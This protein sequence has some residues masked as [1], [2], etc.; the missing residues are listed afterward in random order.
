MSQFIPG[1][2]IA[3]K[4]GV[5]YCV[6]WQAGDA[7]GVT[8]VR[9][10]SQRRVKAANVIKMTAEDLNLVTAPGFQEAVDATVTR[11]RRGEEQRIRRE[12]MTSTERREAAL[13]E[14]QQEDASRAAQ[15]AA[16]AEMSG[17][18]VD[19]PADDEARVLSPMGG[20]RQ[21][22]RMTAEIRAM[23][24]DSRPVQ[25]IDIAQALY[26]AGFRATDPGYFGSGK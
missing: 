9:G 24:E 3:T 4:S 15:R 7:L 2:V 21:V 16:V 8:P 11:V 13:A 5:F 25:A 18:T 22:R 23:L 1:D 26:D 17:P 20:G 14:A 6:L 12:A 10:G 19:A